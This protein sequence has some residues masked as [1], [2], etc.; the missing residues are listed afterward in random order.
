MN[1]LLKRMLAPVHEA[2]AGLQEAAEDNRRQG[3]NLICKGVVKSAPGGT[4]VVVRIGENTTPPIQF[5]VPAAGVTSHYR[6]P[7]PGEIAIVLNF[8][9]GDNFDSCV[10]LCGLCSDS[11]PFPTDNPDEVMTAY[12]EKA[13]TKVD[14][15]SGKLTIHAAGGVEFV[16]TP[17]VKNTEGEIADK[18]RAM[19]LDRV[20]YDTHDHPGDSGGKTGAANQKQGG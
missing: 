8:G 12:G 14:I 19:S 9:T 15:P 20:I 7:S 3:N 16:G 5:L 1:G 4:R 2:L 17:E 13:Y 10:A 11:F 6:C 18:V